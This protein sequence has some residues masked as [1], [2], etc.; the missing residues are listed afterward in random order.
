MPLKITQLPPA[1]QTLSARVMHRISQL[2]RS[3]LISSFLL[4]SVGT[5]AAGAVT[6]LSAPIISRLYSPA[7]FGTLAV[8]A[9]ALSLLTTAG[10]F[11]YELAIPIAE[12]D[13]VAAN[14]IAV[15][16]GLVLLNVLVLMGL[17]ALVAGNL[18]SLL[19]FP[20]LA[21]YLWLVPVG[22]LFTSLYQITCYWAIRKQAYRRIART[23]I[24]QSVGC[25][26]A[27]VSIG[28]LAGSAWG[29]F[30]GDVIG[31]AG[32]SIVMLRHLA[33]SWP[34]GGPVTPKR[35]WGAMRRYAKFP[36]LS[37][38]AGVFSTAGSQLPVLL[39][40]RFF[41]VEAAGLYALSSRVLLTPSSLLGG[42]LGQAFL[43]RAAYLRSDRDEL[44]RVTERIAVGTLAWGFPALVF[45][46]VEGPHLFAQIFGQRW[47]VAGIYAQRL[48][49]WFFV[50]LVSSPLSQLLTV[51]EWQGTT[52]VY[53]VLECAVNSCALFVG[54][55]L[56]SAQAGVVALSIAGFTL[57][58]FTTSRYLHAGYSNWTRILLQVAPFAACA[59]VAFAFVSQVAG[60]SSL[61]GLGVRFTL[62]WL[63]YGPLVWCFRMYGGGLCRALRPAMDD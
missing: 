61:L 1:E 11:R 58:I 3:S 10:S 57:T 37:A 55:W 63:C 44:R 38:A 59:M 62:L 39:L 53:A 6:I 29:L 12:T 54:V 4:L 30:I 52:L 45:V 46:M 23:R 36:L 56:K 25:A 22:F 18:L 9:A 28:A 16:V 13:D 35:A 27:Q 43:G 2:R 33:A 14:L 15:S 51:R 5:V 21:P 31:R 47:L 26:L 50:W 32:G 17:V 48:A 8:Y 60:A 7:A 19:H 20:G 41:G 42:A 34:R 24:S 49:P 40:A